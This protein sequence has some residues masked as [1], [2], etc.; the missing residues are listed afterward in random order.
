MAKTPGT[1]GKYPIV[2]LVAAGGMGE[3]YKG[4]HPTLDRHV[5]LKKLTLRGNPEFAERFR[6]EAKILMDF[7]NDNIVDVYDHFKEGRSHYIVLEYIDGLSVEQ[8]VRQE[9]Y[10]PD[11]VALYIFYQVAKALAYAHDRGV[12]HR[13]IKPANILISRKGDVKL[14]DFGIASCKE[15]AEAGLTREG[16]TLG[17]PSY[18]APEQFEN[19]RNVDKRADIYSLGVL[20]YECVTGRKP[21][22]GG[23]S[24]DLI[25]AI[26]KGKYPPPHRYNP[27]TGGLVRLLIKRCMHPKRKRRYSSLDPLIGRLENYLQ[28]RGEEVQKQQLR[29]AV[30]GKKMEAVQPSRGRKVRR[31]LSLT[32]LFALFLAAA[33]GFLY[34]GGWYHRLFLSGSHGELQVDLR[35]SGVYRQPEDYYLRAWL[36]RD[37]GDDA[38]ELEDAAL[39]FFLSRSDEDNQLYHY[40]SRA[41]FLPEGMYRIK[42][43]AESAVFW[44][45]FQIRP[46]DDPERGVKKLTFSLVPR[47]LPLDVRF[48]VQDGVSG[49]EITDRSSIYLLRGGR[50]IPWSREME[51]ELSS[52]GIYRFQVSAPG[53]KAKTFSLLIRE[54][55]HI[56]HIH[57]S[58]ERVP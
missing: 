50:R 54:D 48:L 5:I 21:Y 6:R 31:L 38:E 20:L 16:M 44:K 35:L 4:I 56:I 11:D 34:A 52:G 23:F 58:L 41:K 10:L 8:L 26:S 43:Q 51:E 33:A 2:E 9:R 1:I 46:L 42:V 53:Y 55:Q 49:E 32:I 3:V 17:S 24:A 29:R 28:R 19:S 47:K 13:D 22:P 45:T 57:P 15:D 14:V 30:A 25:A 7:R 18:M 36:F 40:T 39:R 12:I 27:K 37:T